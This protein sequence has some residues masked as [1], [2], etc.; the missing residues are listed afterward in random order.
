MLLFGAGSYFMTMTLML[1]V[2]N[3]SGSTLN[4]NDSL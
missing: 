3:L 4:V 2:L 1:I